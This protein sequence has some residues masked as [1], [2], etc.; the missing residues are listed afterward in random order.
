MN[1]DLTNELIVELWLPCRNKTGKMIDRCVLMSSIYWMSF[2]IL[3]PF[4]M[5][6]IPKWVQLSWFS[7]QKKFSMNWLTWHYRTMSVVTKYFSQTKF[8]LIFGNF[9]CRSITPCR[10][11]N[12]FWQMRQYQKILTL[13]HYNGSLWGYFFWL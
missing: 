5:T 7:T 3:Q 1:T 8:C 6:Q 9:A 11:I 13:S 12:G 2:P 4:K 10:N